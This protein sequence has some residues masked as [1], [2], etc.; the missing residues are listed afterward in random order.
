M[1]EPLGFHQCFGTSALSQH[2]SI[3]QNCYWA[4]IDADMWLKL[5][6]PTYPFIIICVFI[7][8]RCQSLIKGDKC[9]DPKRFRDERKVV[10]QSTLLTTAVQPQPVKMI[11]LFS[12]R[13][14][15]RPD[16]TE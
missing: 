4:L 11:L 9:G 14:I 2:W 16:T 12:A 13:S 7:V 1:F 6:N 8:H 10:E 5:T 3:H 15:G